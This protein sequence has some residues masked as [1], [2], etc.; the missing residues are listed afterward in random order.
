MEWSEST[1]RKPLI[2]R[3]ARQTGKTASVRE[4]A[5][6]FELFLELN[7]ERFEDLALIR[8][9]SSAEDLLAGLKARFNVAAFPERT[10]VFLDEIQESAEAIH[11]LRFLREDHPEL[12]VVAAGS[13]MEVRLQ[14]RGFAFPVGRVTFRTLRPL[15]F[16]EFLRA[17]ENDVL[18]SQIL[19]SA[20]GW[21]P[22]QAPVHEQATEL[23]QTYLQ[24][25]GMPEAVASWVES[26]QPAAASRVHADLIQ[27]LA[28]DL[29]K[30]RGVRDLT[31]LEAAFESLRHH[32]GLRFKY[33]NFAPGY[34]SQLMKAALGKLDAALL[35]TQAWPT[36]SLTPPLVARARSA[37]KLLPL[38]TALALATMG[39]DSEELRRWPVDKILGGRIAEMF[40]GQELLAGRGPS[41]EELYFWVSESSRSNAEIDFLLSAPGKLVPV[42]AKSSASGSLKS[43]HQFLWRSGLDE[44]V[45]LHSGP[46]ADERHEVKMPGG[47]LHYRLLSLPL[48]L[49]SL[50][51][52][53]ISA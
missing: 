47:V 41:H 53:L 17:S 50:I 3:G 13:L 37:P 29:Q 45:R 26:G 46:V 16:M 40:V 33:E 48:Y 2:L 20:S 18:A 27:S 5:K 35:I 11:W 44:A 9:S 6:R 24:I 28:E 23:F 15:S 10:L 30:Y 4:L 7:L 31:Y 34:R 39:F 42:E 51:P 8:A 14:E 32:Y 19:E 43:L 21:Q 49:A 1:G 38:D 25:G 52:D 22:I 36:S 12:A